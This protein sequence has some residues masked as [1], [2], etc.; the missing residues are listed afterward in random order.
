MSRHL[1]QKKQIKDFAQ[2]N[3]PEMPGDTRI[4]QVPG[5]STKLIGTENPSSAKDTI[6]KVDK[7]EVIREEIN[8][9]N[10]NITNL[11][12]LYAEL[13]PMRGIIVRME[14]INMTVL[15][16]GLITE[17][18]VEII[19]GTKS[20]NYIKERRKASYQFRRVGV[21]VA[22]SQSFKDMLYPGSIVQVTPDI[23]LPQ[24]PSD[25]HPEVMPF[26]FVHHSCDIDIQQP[27]KSHEDQHFGYF[28]LKDPMAQIECIIKLNKPD[29]QPAN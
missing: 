14:R 12:P 1:G 2:K 7:L 25:E 13:K 20:G 9:Y 6:E 27:P 24:K 26:S 16:S 3:F 23:I 28:M 4:I 5:L 29:E 8:E 22:V 17:P 18:S 15:P 10:K 11:D 21:V 19:I